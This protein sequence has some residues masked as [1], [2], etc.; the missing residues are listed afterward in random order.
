[1]LIHAHEPRKRK[2]DPELQLLLRDRQPRLHGDQRVRLEPGKQLVAQR[3]V[4]VH[5][6]QVAV[7]V[8]V[9]L[10]KLRQFF[11]DH[12]RIAQID[13]AAGFP[14]HQVK[15]VHDV[16]FNFV[17]HLIDAAVVVI[18]GLAVDIGAVGNVFDG[19]LIH[20]LFR[21]QGGKGVADGAFG[22]AHPAF[23]GFI[24]HGNA[25]FGSVSVVL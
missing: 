24:Q 8:D 1:M 11:I 19:D 15:V 17:H 2:V 6:Q 21:Q 22:F 12:G 13:A 18:E 4:A 5:A 25:P 16:V 10:Q 9:L 14:Q 23:V 7:K 3:V 20:V